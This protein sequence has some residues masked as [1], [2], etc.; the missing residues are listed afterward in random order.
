MRSEADLWHEAWHPSIAP[1]L[2]ATV[3]RGKSAGPPHEM[4]PSPHLRSCTSLW[5]LWPAAD[6]MACLCDYV[7]FPHPPTPYLAVIS[8]IN[9]AETWSDVFQ[10]NPH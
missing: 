8:C 3:S 10:L 9:W 5:V 6:L 7:C 1:A 2:G 4:T